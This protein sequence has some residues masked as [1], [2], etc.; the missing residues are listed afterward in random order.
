MALVVSSPFVPCYISQTVNFTINHF[1]LGSKC[2]G[3]P[4]FSQLWEGPASTP[5]FI[6][7]NVTV[8]NNNIPPGD[9]YDAIPV[10]WEAAC[11]FQNLDK[12]ALQAFFWYKSTGCVTTGSQP[13][14]PADLYVGSSGL[15]CYT[16]IF[17]GSDI[18]V[19]HTCPNYVVSSAPSLALGTS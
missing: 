19:N 6:G 7:L 16:G 14:T 1:P 11:T 5:A 3:A 17:N 18:T 13:E 9:A 4:L 8:C 10:A 2:A 12:G 15:S